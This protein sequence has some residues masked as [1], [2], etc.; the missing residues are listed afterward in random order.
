MEIWDLYTEDRICTGLE[1]I[2]GQELPDGLYHLVVHVWIRN[3]Q[4]K[5]LISQRAASRPTHPLMWECVGGSVLK[6][7]SSLQGALREAQEEVGAQLLPHRGRVVFSR[8]RKTINGKK[9]NDIM[10][11]W[12]FEHDGE[13]SLAQATTDEV[14]QSRWMDAREIRALYDAG[15]LVHTLSYF[16][17]EVEREN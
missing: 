17:T 6:G 1:H 5:Y 15:K 13:I 2:R 9:A 7:E 12:L 10:D 3:P 4:G 8:L 11:V 16:F 14:A